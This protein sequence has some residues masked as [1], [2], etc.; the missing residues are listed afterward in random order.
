MTSIGRYEGP[1]SRDR[2]A[3]RQGAPRQ[4]RSPVSPRRESSR[5]EGAT[6]SIPESQ[7]QRTRIVLSVRR[8]VGLL[9]ASLPRR[10]GLASAER[11]RDRGNRPGRHGARERRLRC[12]GPRRTFAPPRR[13]SG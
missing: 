12:M 13:A 7:P 1:P 4:S 9:G 6:A 3:A 8:H 11:P 2:G 5:H 10:V